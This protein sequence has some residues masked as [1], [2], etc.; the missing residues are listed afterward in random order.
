MTMTR[1]FKVRALFGA[2]AMSLM[3]V[4]ASAS[5]QTALPATPNGLKLYIVE[6]CEP[7]DKGGRCS[8]ELMQ[9]PASQASPTNAQTTCAPGWVA[10]FVGQVGTVEKGGINRGAAIVCGYQSEE[11][12]LR[13]AIKVCDERMTNIC[14]QANNI[15]VTWGKWDEMPVPGVTSGQMLDASQLPQ[16]RFCRSDVPLV[17]SPENCPP[18]AAVQL[19]SAGVR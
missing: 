6:A 14:S 18:S 5:A 3:G 11:A 12:A 13:A 16:A 4:T 19:R 9:M 15:N 2:V 10:H 17:E 1:Q 7:V 8:L